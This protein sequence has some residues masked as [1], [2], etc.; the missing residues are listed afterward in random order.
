VLPRV[1]STFKERFPEVQLQVMRSH[2]ARTVQS[3]LDNSVDFGFTQLPVQEKRLE[4]VQVHA[5]EIRLLVPPH[6][7]L[8]NSGKVGPEQIAEFPLLLPKSGRTRARLNEYLEVVQDDLKISME[9]ES[10]EM[11]KQFIMAGL[12]VGFMAV[13]NARPEIEAKELRAVPLAPMPMIHTIG[14]IYRKDKPLSRASLGFIEVIA[15][16]ARSVAAAP[17]ETAAF[18]PRR[19]S[20]AS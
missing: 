18:T 20:K 2:G 8:A 4:V 3:V 10:T 15:D 17:E 9:L 12:G 19:T 5:D 6:H 1:F 11:L 7:P 14:L 13:T 16:F